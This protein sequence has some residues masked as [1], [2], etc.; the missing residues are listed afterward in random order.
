M[1][2]QCRIFKAF[3]QLYHYMH[4]EN[5]NNSFYATWVMHVQSSTFKIRLQYSLIRSLKY[6]FVYGKVEIFQQM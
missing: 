5:S 6:M 4:V 3:F 1:Y 2:P